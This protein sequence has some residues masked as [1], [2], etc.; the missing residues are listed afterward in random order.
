MS[1]NTNNL[2]VITSTSGS[3]YLQHYQV[4][5]IQPHC[6]TNSL[7][8]DYLVMELNNKELEIS[9]S[10]KEHL[11]K[12][13]DFDARRH[14]FVMKYPPD[15]LRVAFTISASNYTCF[16]PFRIDP[17]DLSCELKAG[18]LECD[19]QTRRRI[20]L[21]AVSRILESSKRLLYLE[22]VKPNWNK[23]SWKWECFTYE[24][25]AYV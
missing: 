18:M 13:Q 17:R 15:F 2:R 5:S 22:I 4:T 19:K 12:K 8:E 1:T 10:I 16:P 25:G 9:E 20:V 14:H 3:S 7:V 6:W 11:S 23:L 21:N 24:D